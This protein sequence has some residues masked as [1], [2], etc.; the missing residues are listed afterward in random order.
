VSSRRRSR[1][2]VSR[3]R[4]PGTNEWP[5]QTDTLWPASASQR[6]DPRR[7]RLFNPRDDYSQLS[8]VR[9][10]RTVRNALLSDREPGE[11]ADESAL[12]LTLA[13]PGQR[14]T[15]RL[16]DASYISGRPP[17]AGRAAQPRGRIQLEVKVSEQLA[18]PHKDCR[19]HLDRKRWHC[20]TQRSLRR[21]HVYGQHPAQRVAVFTQPPHPSPYPGLWN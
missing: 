17:I 19:S 13:H 18:A 7:L 21:T 1:L 15:D 10:R 20:R 3:C 6:P 14:H 2:D 4:A 9:A 5:F 11:T 12:S 16:R 8:F